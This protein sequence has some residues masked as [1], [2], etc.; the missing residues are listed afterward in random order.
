MVGILAP[1]APSAHGHERL[2]EAGLMVVYDDERELARRFAVRA[3][4]TYVILDAEGVIH[5]VH[6]GVVG[7]EE[8]GRAVLAVVSEGGT[9][10]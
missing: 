4:P 2:G 9:D 3:T 1:H 8:L 6:E 7:P 5:W 10:E